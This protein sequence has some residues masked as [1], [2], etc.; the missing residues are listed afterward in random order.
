MIREYDENESWP[1]ISISGDNPSS[2]IADFSK[3]DLFSKSWEE[4]RHYDGLS[5]KNAKRRITRKSNTLFGQDVTPK[6]EEASMMQPAGIYGASSKQINP[7]KNYINGYGAFDVITPPHNLYQLASFYDSNF[8]NHASVLAKVMNVV[9][10][11]Y[12]F[13]M[14]PLAKQKKAD[15]SSDKD[16][17]F[18]DKKINRLKSEITAFLESLNSVDSFTTTMRKVVTDLESTGNGYIEIGRTTR[19]TIGYIGHI[20]STTIRVRR[21][22]DGYVQIIANKVVYFRNY[23]ATNADPIGGD[24]APNEIIHLKKYSPLNTYYGVPDI[25]S[26]IPSLIGDQLAE[27]YNIDYFDNKAVPRY[28]VTLKGAKLSPDSED[29]LFRFLQ[30]NLKGQS[31]RTLYIPLP[32]DTMDNKVEFKMEPVENKVQ[33]SSFKEFRKSNRDNILMA[34]QVPLSKLGSSDSS[35]VASAISQDRT[36]RDQVCRPLQQYV[37][38]SISS[39]V[40]EQTNMIE[41]RFNEMNI[42]DEVQQ[43][44]VHKTYADIG[45][46]LPNEIREKIGMPTIEGLDDRKERIERER[47]ELEAKSVMERNN[48]RT[49][50]QSDG[51]GAATGR[52]PKGSGAKE[53]NNVA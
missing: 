13:D 6:Y 46:L 7:G 44:T 2:S 40:S 34:H 50:Q 30:T 38:K 3:H 39:I 51:A 37:E 15:A 8:A 5:D 47:M 27:Q 29:R 20:P 31:H 4:L 19:G 26:A 24:P 1:L 35:A 14:S 48:Q 42:V 16:I 53:D 25:A 36:F 45:V 32:S 17:A 52:N 9:G 41:L 23:K 11:G 18:I 43:S 10:N 28:I 21:L 22:R 33:E 12:T 49:Q